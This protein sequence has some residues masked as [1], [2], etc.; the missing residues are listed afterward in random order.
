M[1]RLENIMHGGEITICLKK[2]SKEPVLLVE[3]FAGKKYF[4]SINESDLP[5]V[6]MAICH[7]KITSVVYWF[8][9]FNYEK[10]IQH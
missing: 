10:E 7:R 5:K 3:K 1:N 4:Y 8:S 6:Y 9:L 2:D